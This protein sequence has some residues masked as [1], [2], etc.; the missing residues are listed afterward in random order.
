MSTNNVR[1]FF[2]MIDRHFP[3]ANA[4]GRFENLPNGDVRFG[5]RYREWNRMT[6][7]SLT[8]EIEPERRHLKQTTVR[9]NDADGIPYEFS[10][11]SVPDIDRR[12]SGL[13]KEILGEQTRGTD[14]RL[15]TTKGKSL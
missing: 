8:A 1:E 4:T 7:F 10:S 3:A 14:G 9:W 6:Q 15:S 5:I 11:R 12:L 2:A 13:R